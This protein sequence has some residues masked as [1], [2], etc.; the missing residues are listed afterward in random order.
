MFV[1]Y[2]AVNLLFFKGL[3]SMLV[4]KYLCFNRGIWLMYGI[5]GREPV[6][7]HVCSSL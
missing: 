1:Q 3:H 4:E 6:V 2:E 7:H 5:M